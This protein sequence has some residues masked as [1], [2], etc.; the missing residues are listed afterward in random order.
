MCCVDCITCDG[1]AAF[2]LNQD[3]SG[4]LD[5]HSLSYLITIWQ[6][7]MGYDHIPSCPLILCYL[8]DMVGCY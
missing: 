4:S 3:V 5:D 6:E 8:Y 2:V 7:Y 1:L